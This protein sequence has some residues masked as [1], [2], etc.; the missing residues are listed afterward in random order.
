MQLLPPFLNFC[1]LHILMHNK[2]QQFEPNLLNVFSVLTLAMIIHTASSLVSLV[3][4][5]AG[6]K[7]WPMI[8]KSKICRRN[9]GCAFSTF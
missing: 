1:R 8:D 6:A 4:A 5:V 2:V 3:Q 9:S 7:M